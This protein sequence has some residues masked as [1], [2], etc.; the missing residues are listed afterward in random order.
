[1]KSS[2]G[3]HFAGLDHLRALAAFMVICWHFTPVAIHKVD[4]A[5]VLM[6]L[7]LLHEGNTGVSLFMALS[8]YLFAKLLDGRDILFGEFVRNRFLRLAPLLS[9]VLAIEIWN[10]T[11]NQGWKFHRATEFIAKGLVLPTWPN[12][13]WSIA[14]EFHFYLLL[15]F[16]LRWSRNTVAPLIAL[17][18][19]AV[20]LR[21]G[22]HFLRGN[23]QDLAYWTIGGR[24][25]QFV[26]G[27]LAWRCRHLATGRHTA[28]AFGAFTAFW[29]WLDSHGGLY[30][31]RD[32]AIWI[33]QP[34]IE[35]VAWAF[36]IAWYDARQVTDQSR[37]SRI[38]GAFGSISFSL[39]LLHFYWIF[40]YARSLADAGYPIEN[41][42]A[43]TMA[44][45]VFYVLMFFPAWATHQLME[46]PFLRWRRSYIATP[47]ATRAP[48]MQEADKGPAA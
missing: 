27:I 3:V 45:L 39:Y 37:I 17:L 18:V 7:S 29:W 44:A 34:A 30:G 36:L 1:M 12:G 10:L 48:G 41:Q 9:V 47:G 28:I 46:R 5:P 4:Q 6:P 11:N 23:I 42:Y 14:V 19:A 15:P 13:G 8:G 33:L 22:V 25:D 40:G 2:T 32:S 43:A 35:G 38:I 31:T 20:A 24:I 16:L 21:T 26:L